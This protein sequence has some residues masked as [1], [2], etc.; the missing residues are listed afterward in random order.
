VTRRLNA[1][2][3]NAATSSLFETGQGQQ[4]PRVSA[5]KTVH[6]LDIDTPYDAE[7]GQAHRALDLLRGDL[8][9]QTTAGIPGAQAWVGGETAESVDEDHHLAVGLPWVVAFVVGLTMLIMGW[10]FRSVVIA[11]TT[12]FVNL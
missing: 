9:P 2:Q 3:R 8:V 11:L 4:P 7:S 1:L 6:V 12:A 5:D 10:V